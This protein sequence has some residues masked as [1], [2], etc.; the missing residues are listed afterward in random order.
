[1]VSNRIS[2]IIKITLPVISSD[3]DSSLFINTAP[4]WGFNKAGRCQMWEADRRQ[5]EGICTKYQGYFIWKRITPLK[6]RAALLAALNPAEFTQF[7]TDPAEDFDGI[8]K[9]FA[10]W[11]HA[12]HI[13][14]LTS[15][16]SPKKTD[17]LNNAAVHKAT[18]A[19]L[20]NLMT[21]HLFL[22]SEFISSISL[23]KYILF[24]HAL[25]IK[26]NSHQQSFVHTRQH[27]RRW[28]VWP[29]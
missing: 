27:T 13:H 20:L 23:S 14:E 22:S 9:P 18:P 17:W 25:K 24:C 8:S 3:P 28:F 16:L 2:Q 19:A 11:I 15:P 12:F 7:Y 21:W 29:G 10:V 26:A 1:M 5:G 4:W 6:G